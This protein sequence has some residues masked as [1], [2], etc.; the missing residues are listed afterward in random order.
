M[1]QTV[2]WVIKECPTCHI[3]FAITEQHDNRLVNTKESAYCPSGHSWH[4]IGKTEAQRWKEQYEQIDNQ[5]KLCKSDKNELFDEISE[6]QNKTKDLVRSRG[7]YKG[8]V[9]KLKQ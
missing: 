2:S 3:L 5:L 4:Y 1:Q 8:I 7:Y 6:L 9:T